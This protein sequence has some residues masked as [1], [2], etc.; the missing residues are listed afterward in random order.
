[1]NAIILAGGESRRMG[2][3]KAFI[4]IGGV[5]VI[6]RQVRLLKQIF[7]KI[8]IVTNQPQKYKLRGV[9]VVCDIVPRCGPL[10]GIYSGLLA[11]DSFH[12]FVVA[13]DMPFINAS[14]I[15]YLLKNK[16]NYD[17]LIPQIN[18]ENHPL[19]GL[20]SKNCIPVIEEKLR[21]HILK[22]ITILP[23]V[24]SRFLSRQEIRRFDK[25]MLSLVNVNTQE[26]LKKVRE[27]KEK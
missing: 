23:K 25:G 15:K 1:M 19:F 14:L 16:N 8:I 6:K 7:K 22:V 11:S 18:K 27:R 13:C 17:M 3:N 12:N 5:P 10:A 9:K 24:K 4:K 26:D 20:Y 21:Q 2:F